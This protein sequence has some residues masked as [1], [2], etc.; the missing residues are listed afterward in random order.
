[1]VRLGAVMGGNDPTFYALI[2]S[3]LALY[4]GAGFIVIGML[5][6]VAGVILRTY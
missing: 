6:I 2:F 4:T 1:M 5:F 3:N